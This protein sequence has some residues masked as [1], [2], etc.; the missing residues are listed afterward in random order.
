MKNFS[1]KQ[2]LILVGLITGTITALIIGFTFAYWTWES[3]SAQR[4]AVSFTVGNGFSC[5]ADGGGNITSSDVTLAPADCTDSNYAIKRTVTTSLTN[6]TGNDVFMDMWLTVNSIDDGL[7]NSDY[8]RYALTTDSNS[9]TNNLVAQGNF[10]GLNANDKVNLLSGIKTSGT[11]YLWIWLDKLETSSATQNQSF[12]LS[13]G[14]ECTNDTEEITL[15]NKIASQADLTTN[16]NFSQVSSDTNGKGVYRFA[17]TENN[18]YPIYYY[19]GDINNNNVKFANKCWKIVRTTETGGVKL[20]YSGVPGNIYEQQLPILE[21]DYTISTNTGNFTWDNTDSTWNATITDGQN[22]E[23]SFTVPT[24]DNYNFVMT[25]TTGSSTGGSY[26]IY[27][28]DTQVYGNGGGGGQALSY[29]HD[30]G[31]LTA[32][33][34]IKFVYQGS[35]TTESPITFKIKMTKAGGNLLGVGCNNTG[36]ATYISDT[37]TAF[38]PNYDSPSYVGYMYGDVYTYA[39]ATGTGLMYAPDVTYANGI[40]TL[41]SKDSY[42]IETKSAISGTNLSYHHYTCGSVSETTCTSVRYV[43]YVAG[44]IAYYIT[45]SNGKKVEDAIEDMLTNSSNSTDS[46]IKGVIDNWYSTN[47]TS[48][49]NYL[50]DTVYCNDRSINNLTASGW[51]PSGGSISTSLYFNGYNRAYTSYTPSLNCTNKND[52]FTVNE[53]S[54]G[55]G[56]LTY[57]VGLLTSD[58]AMLAGMKGGSGGANYLN[59]STYYWLVSPDCWNGIY[60]GGFDVNFGS[61]SVEDMTTALGARPSVSLKPGMKISGGDGSE[62]TPYEIKIN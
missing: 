6:T 17:G 34:V 45:L 62:I 51:N 29:S 31:S 61:L 26:Y 9:C 13:L 50:E 25:G 28:D 40:Y 1:E 18:A 58:E 3:T 38:N 37:K 22:K 23:I 60:A 16:I 30:F 12:N 19:R 7:K 57:P 59:S 55:N 54:T 53:S 2:K 32:S 15:Y 4:T 33:N 24:D 11:Y 14:G 35:S 56:K 20:I 5:S 42:N 21:S 27:K 8:F 48:Y 52:A 36:T 47:M 41:T 10:K 43:Y 46:T 39:R 49:T 44:N